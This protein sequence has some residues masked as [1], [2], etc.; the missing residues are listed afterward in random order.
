MARGRA[1]INGPERPCCRSRRPFGSNQAM[2][3]G[4]KAVQRNFLGET[5][6]CHSTS[7]SLPDCVQHIWNC[8]MNKVVAPFPKGREIR[9]P[10][11]QLC[12]IGESHVKFGKMHASGCLPLSWVAFKARRGSRAACQGIQFPETIRGAGQGGRGRFG[13][14]A[15][16]DAA[17]CGNHGPGSRRPRKA[18]RGTRNGFSESPGMRP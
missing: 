13:E 12:R 3:A 8:P 2:I 15:E 10:V 16:A 14:P 18:S 1:G 6:H 17:T 11:A 4:R 7:V 9:P 5:I